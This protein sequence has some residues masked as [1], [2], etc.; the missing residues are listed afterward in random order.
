M[1]TTVFI[2]NTKGKF[3]SKPLPVEAQISPVYA[4]AADD[5]DGDGNIDILLGGNL[6]QAKPE[7]GI[8]DASY[9]LMLRGD[10]K[11]NFSALTPQQSGINIRGAVRDIVPVMA[12]KKKLMLIGEN[13][14]RLKIITGQA[15]PAR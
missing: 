1:N 5:Y 13:N 8:Y 15:K 2:N 3:I 9:G 14:G 11:G 7:V 6:Y 4:V 12:G 10:G